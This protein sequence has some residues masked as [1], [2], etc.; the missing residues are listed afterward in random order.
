M[1]F[2]RC[3][4]KVLCKLF[5]IPQ[6]FIISQ[7]ICPPICIVFLNLL[8]T[9]VWMSWDGNRCWGIQSEPVARCAA[10]VWAERGAL[11]GRTLNE[12][13]LSCQPFALA[14]GTGGNCGPTRVPPW[15][16]QL[17]PSLCDCAVNKLLYEMRYTKLCQGK[18]GVEQVGNLVWV[19]VNE[20]CREAGKALVGSLKLLAV[21]VL[22]PQ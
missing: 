10:A 4:I 16:H 6:L 1:E 11:G 14:K 7:W 3:W 20:V 15:Q 5:L 2:S 17:E 18:T 8:I 19:H 21:K 9:L 12:G 22:W 13:V